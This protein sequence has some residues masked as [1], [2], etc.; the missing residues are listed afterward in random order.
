M[1]SDIGLATNLETSGWVMIEG[2]PVGHEDAPK[3]ADTPTVDKDQDQHDGRSGLNVIWDEAEFIEGEGP[4]TDD[5]APTDFDQ[6]VSYIVVINSQERAAI[7][8]GPFGPCRP[9]CQCP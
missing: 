4:S 7:P 2:V 8:H 3:R 9:H 5:P 1:S 6:K